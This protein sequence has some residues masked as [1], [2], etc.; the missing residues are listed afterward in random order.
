AKTEDVEDLIRHEHRVDDMDD[1]QRPFYLTAGIGGRGILKSGWNL[2]EG[3]VRKQGIKDVEVHDEDANV[4]GNVPTITEIVEEGI[5][6]DHSTTSVVDPRDF[7][8]NE[9]ARAL[10]PWE[11]GGA[12]YLFHRMYFS[13]EQLKDMERS[14]FLQNVDYL[15]DKR[16]QKSD[17][18]TSRASE[19]FDLDRT[20]DQIEVL[21]YWCYEDG[22]VHRCWIGNQSVV[23]RDLEDSPFWHGGYPFIL[24]TSM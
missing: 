24:G 2:V 19:V 13:F 9:S 15:K 17:E 3:A 6:R 1:K 20:K 4:I 8:V 7:L 14:G 11:E 5:L 21:E 22:L 18:Y 12:Q 10:Q 23:L 16:D